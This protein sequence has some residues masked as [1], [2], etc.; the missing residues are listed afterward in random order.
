ML[1]EG[2]WFIGVSVLLLLIEK[3]VCLSDLLL[4]LSAFFARHITTAAR[5][6]SEV[7]GLDRP[8]CNTFCHDGRV[9]FSTRERHFT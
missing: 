7:R 2:T 4:E 9:T 5:G 3:V 8:V 6:S 1:G